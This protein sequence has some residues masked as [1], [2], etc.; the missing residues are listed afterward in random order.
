MNDIKVSVL[1]A[2]YNGEKYVKES[3]ESVLN[4]SYSNIELLIGFNGTKDNSKEIV[5]EFNDSRIKIFDFGMDKGK[6]KTINK[7]L[8][9]SSGDWLA[10]QD[11]DDV[12]LPKKIQEQVKYIEEYDIIGTQILYIN[13]YGI[14]TGGPN[15]ATNHED[16]LLKSLNG[17]NQIANTSAIFKK[18]KALEVGGWDEQLDG[19]E[20][21]DFWLKMMVN[22]KCKVKNLNKH[23]TWHRLHPIS[24]FNT[25]SF[26]LQSLLIKYQK[27]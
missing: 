18:S 11:D 19:V 1:L 20:D 5:S 26:D 15:L 22:A 16:I 24:N 14:I 13:K 25:K 9:E 27:L 8:V 3:I 10:I 4:Q 6:A 7:L 2:I 12:W 17:D 21:Y 23:H